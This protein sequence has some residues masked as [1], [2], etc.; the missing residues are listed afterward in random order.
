VGRGLVVP[1][2]AP[3]PGVG[4]APD[5]ERRLATVGAQPAT[6]RDTQL[7]GE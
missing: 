4:S 2:A 1:P 6:R 7:N 3:P 5:G